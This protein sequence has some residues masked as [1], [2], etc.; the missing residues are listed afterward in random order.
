MSSHLY[1]FEQ[2]LKKFSRK[3]QFSPE[4]LQLFLELFWLPVL[5]GNNASLK[6]AIFLWKALIHSKYKFILV[7]ERLFFQKQYWKIHVLTL[8]ITCLFQSLQSTVNAFCCILPQTA[9][10]NWSSCQEITT[11]LCNMYEKA[12]SCTRSST[13]S[14]VKVQ[15]NERRCYSF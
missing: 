4:R 3:T 1:K 15:K 10:L 9:T 8:K 6:F 12:V 11:Y 14:L 2:F 13:V 5:K 7:S